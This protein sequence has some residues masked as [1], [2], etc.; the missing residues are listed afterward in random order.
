MMG[1]SRVFKIKEGIDV[2]TLNTGKYF[3]YRNEKNLFTCLSL[4]AEKLACNTNNI[5]DFNRY[6][7]YDEVLRITAWILRF[8]CKHRKLLKSQF[9]SRTS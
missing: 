2:W 1:R 5:I 3:W 4:N 6:S 9:W 8:I 7:S